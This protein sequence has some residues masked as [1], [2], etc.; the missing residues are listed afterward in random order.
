VKRSLSIAA[1]L[2]FLG[3]AALVARL[4]RTARRAA[5]KRPR[6]LRGPVAMVGLNYNQQADARYG[7]ESAVLVERIDAFA[8]PYVF[9]SEVTGVI[10]DDEGSS[11]ARKLKL[12]L[13][14]LFGYD[15][16]VTFFD[17]SFFRF[18][19][20]HAYLH[21]YEAPLL[22]LAGIKIVAVPYGA[23]VQSFGEVRSRFDWVERLWRDYEGRYGDRT[24]HNA[25]VRAQVDYLSRHADVVVGGDHSLV[26]FLPRVDVNFK[27][28]PIDTEAWRP[29]E[30]PRNESVVV[31]HA[32]NHRNVKGTDIL[33]ASSERLARAGYAHDLRLVERVPRDQVKEIYASADVLAEQFVM[34]AYGLTALEAMALGKPVL[35]YCDEAQ[36]GDPVFSLPV[37]NTNRDNIDDV[38]AAVVALPEL[39]RR[40]GAIGREAV[41]RYQS[42][43]AIGEV[44]DRIYRHLWTGE[45]LRLETTRH[46]DPARPA[47]PLTEDPRNAEFWPVDV[48]DM[49]EE[50]RETLAKGRDAAHLPVERNRA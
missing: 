32:P 20:L 45:E 14:V 47:R 17:G 41:E 13:R 6:I 38:L 40:L 21:R 15:V 3:A 22:H 37:V 23:D 48:S 9:Q 7:Y 2:A 19:T 25:R 1:A 12:F 4:F 27:Y 42:I 44:W 33:L 35:S 28:F 43:D 36:L 8:Y 16:W 5:G 26:P 50:I 24:E 34:G 49:I 10:D 11:L 29:V 39:R 31:V 18:S 46:F 30:T